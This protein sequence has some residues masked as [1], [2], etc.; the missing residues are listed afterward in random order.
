MLR[1][2]L[3]PLIALILGAVIIPSL[4][5]AQQLTPD[6]R[7]AAL[8]QAMT[9]DEKVTLVSGTGSSSRYSRNGIPRLG[10]PP[11]Q[12]G[13]AANGV[14]TSFGPTPDQKSTALPCGLSLASTW[15]PSLALSY[16]QVIGTEAYALG[17]GAVL[18][19]TTDIARVPND[20]RMF[21]AFGEDPLLTGRTAAQFITGVQQSPVVSSPKHYNANNQE[22]NRTA[23]N[24]MIDERTLRE[25]YTRPW[26]LIVKNGAPLGI[27]GA[28][29]AVNGQYV[30]SNYHLLTEILKND[31]QFQGYVQSDFDGSHSTLDA[32][33]GLDF[34]DPDPVFFGDKLKAAVVSGLVPMAR[35][36]DMAYRYVRAITRSGWIDAPSPVIYTNPA[37][38]P[39]LDPQLASAHDQ[40][41]RRVGDNG[42]VL[43]RNQKNIL[44]LSAS[45]KFIALIGPDL[46]INVSG[47]G[48]AFVGDTTNLVT[49]LDGIRARAAQAGATV[50]Y[51]PGVDTVTPGDRLDGPP[52]V[53]SSVLHPFSDPTQNGLDVRYYAAPEY[54]GEPFLSY[55][56]PQVNRESG[57][58]DT[59]PRSFPK[60][61]F[62]TDSFGPIS[63]IWLGTLTPPVSGVYT[64]SLYH[65]GGA[66]LVV[67][68]AVM[69]NASAPQPQTDTVQMTL[70]GG[71]SYDIEINYF[72]DAPTQLANSFGAAVNGGNAMI[73]FGWVPPAG[74]MSPA[75]QAAVNLAK[76]SDTAV[77]VVRD[78]NSE[79]ADRANLTLPQDQNRLIAEVAKVNP[80][81]V[82]VLQ[83]GGPALMPWLQSVSGVLETWYAGQQQGNVVADVLFGDVNPS[84]KL[85][86]SFPMA[87][88]QDPTDGPEQY[89]GTP[90]YIYSGSGDLPQ[91]FYNE[92]LAVG[93]RGYDQFGI[94]PF[95]P[96]GYG[97][98]YTTFTYSGITVAANTDNAQNSHKNTINVS[99]KVTNSGQRAG[100]EVAQVY[101]SFPSNVG[102][103][104][105]QL[106]GWSKV[107]LAPGESRQVTVAID[108][109]S[110][111]KPFSY[112]NTTKSRWNIA[113]GTYNIYVGSSSR[114]I[115]LSGTVNSNVVQTMAGHPDF[116]DGEVALS[117]GVYYL[118]F[119]AN[120]NVFGYYAFLS[121]PNYIYH[122][123]LG[124]EYVFDAKDGHGGVYLYDFASSTF[125]YTS[126]A[127]PF[128]YLYD[129]RLNSVLYYFPD[130]ANPGRYNTNGVRYFY[131]FATGQII[132]K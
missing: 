109:T 49:T 58:A 19:P 51:L 71:Q 96:F 53:P 70:V 91:A 82:V 126:P 131:N 107:A 6:Q 28:L 108:P 88:R 22:F 4:A 79:G 132:T 29:N 8:V 2:L 32:N 33:A 77:V 48:S 56:E 127:F 111:D 35:L 67:N 129:F 37:V 20:G 18:A 121:D 83:T 94:Q 106:A 90:P 120:G 45:T 30:S 103:P 93:Y 16:G 125:F 99:F 118:A 123:D 86:V 42:V 97:L 59:F 128:P 47:G 65:W 60:V 119:P 25:I 68:A 27:L 12:A 62:L 73:R 5:R 72:E 74:T 85:P 21:E 10:I 24:E 36:D 41:A 14:R 11:F 66:R 105:R 50:T 89:P 13:D 122:F 104:P 113:D 54:Y 1:S 31:L 87:D 78:Y 76:S 9:L 69:I 75:L 98:S 116:F 100:S 23:I 43:L 39:P 110:A 80:N 57:L 38:R 84:G 124:Y 61:S 44:P 117:N 40:T 63:A 46:D 26:S 55:V 15:D 52:P 112:W 7:A 114:D 34:E 17:Y 64:L 102:E 81:T 101:L 115:R 92:G 130:P 3:S 95:F